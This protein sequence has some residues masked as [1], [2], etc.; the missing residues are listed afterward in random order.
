MDD[1]LVQCSDIQASVSN[2]SIVCKLNLG[3][4]YCLQENISLLSL[5]SPEPLEEL[6]NSSGVYYYTSGPLL[7]P[8]NYTCSTTLFNEMF[9][10]TP[11]IKSELNHILCIGYPGE[12]HA[13]MHACLLLIT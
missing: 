9:N 2:N 4:D 10:S 5:G 13:C 3:W 6:H 8:G 12:K 7:F 11:V 1:V